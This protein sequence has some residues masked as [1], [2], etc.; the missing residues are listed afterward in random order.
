MDFCNGKNDEYRLKMID[1]F[2]EQVED[3][4]K[5]V[6]AFKVANATSH[7]DEISPHIHIVGV[8]VSDDNK[9]GMKKQVAKSKI[10]TKKSLTEL[11]DKMRNC[12]IKSFNKVYEQN[13]QLKQ[14]KKGRNQDINVKDMG[15]YREKNSWLKKMFAEAKLMEASVEQ[16]NQVALYLFNT[17]KLENSRVQ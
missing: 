9:R 17:I 10:F 12:C 3:L 15:D 11:Q 5:I 14:K 4:Q 6:P 8:P 7:F 1:V 2:K 13:Y 16:Q